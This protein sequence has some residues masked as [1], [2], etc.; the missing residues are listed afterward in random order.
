[1]VLRADQIREM[2]ME[3]LEHKITETRKAIMDAHF[4]HKLGT[5]DN[6]LSIRILRR[7]LSRL[8][9]VR[10]EAHSG[11]RLLKTQ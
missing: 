5:L 7:Q 1:M 2:T 9:T 11:K 6:P 8:C 4:K 10:Q 3:E